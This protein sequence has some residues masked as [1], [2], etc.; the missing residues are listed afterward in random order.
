[1]P[2]L[3]TILL[4]SWYPLRAV[5]TLFGLPLFSVENLLGP[6]RVNSVQ[7]I[8]LAGNWVSGTNNPFNPALITSDT[9]AAF[10]AETLLYILRPLVPAGQTYTAAQIA[11]LFGVT[12][13]EID[14]SE[15]G[16]GPYT[17]A[18]IWTDAGGYPGNGSVLNFANVTPTTI[19]AFTAALS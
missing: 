7:L 11:A 6:Q 4:S 12:A 18:E 9:L 3:T 14:E 10:Q 2:P 17:A 13:A 5:A 16:G 15:L 1:M 19:A 8:A